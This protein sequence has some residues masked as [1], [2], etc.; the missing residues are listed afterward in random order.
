MSFQD[1]HST[2]LEQV[3]RFLDVRQLV[4]FITLEKHV[5]N[6]NNY[7]LVSYQNA[8]DKE[9]AASIVVELEACAILQLSGIEVCRN[10]FLWR[11][12]KATREG[13]EV[14]VKR[15][16]LTRVPKLLHMN[17]VHFFE[18]I[19]HEKR[20]DRLHEAG[21]WVR[22]NYNRTYLSTMD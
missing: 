5:Q 4:V 6:S 16:I 14:L 18:A 2:I 17:F 15:G 8:F 20:L 21:W 10:A 7:T 3:G 1:L 22:H 9:L 12:E 11:C 19:E 13:C